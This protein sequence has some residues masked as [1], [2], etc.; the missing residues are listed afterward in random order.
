MSNFNGASGWCLSALAM[1]LLAIA[2]CASSPLTRSFPEPSPLGSDL[3]SFRAPE[4][5]EEIT[6]PPEEP[7]RTEAKTSGPM[8]LRRA[9]ALALERSPE[10]ASFSWEVRVREGQAQQAGL[11]PNPELEG[12]LEEFAGSGDLKSFDTSESTLL[13]AQ[14]F[15]TAGKR[16]KRRTA[17]ERGTEVAGWEYEAARLRVYASVVKAFTGVLAAQE[18]VA[19]TEELVKVAESSEEAVG[20]LVSAG[21]TPSVERT[22]AGVEAA[23]ARV[24]VAAARRALKA[25]RAELASTWGATSPDFT[26]ADGKIE[27]VVSPPSLDTLRKNLARNP[28]LARW[29]AEIVRQDALVALEDARRFPNVTAG[30]G[31]KHLAEV[32]ETAMVAGFSI[33]LPLFDRNQ[34]ARAAARASLRKAHHERRAEH[35]RLAA[36]LE[37]A[38]QEIA[39]RYEEVTQ[40]REQILPGAREAFTGVREGY[41]QGLFRN[42]DVLDA[43]QRLFELRLREIESLRAYHAARAEVERMTGQPLGSGT[44]SSAGGVKP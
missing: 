24:E 3:R 18:R 30:A 13:L 31:V 26:R 44:G 22:R 9:L 4:S 35:A 17:A 12:E 21:A 32:D 6:S 15:E 19:V 7:A 25:A 37:G 36:A 43:Q 42:V 2:G 41:L 14:T 23:T 39:A 34:G 5:S 29:D 20:R 8:T 16:G 1:A 33:P 40:L 38:Y 27:A 11:R 28:E 10:L